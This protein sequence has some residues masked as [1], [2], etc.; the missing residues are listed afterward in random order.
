LRTGAPRFSA[1]LDEIQAPGPDKFE[2]RRLLNELPGH[3]KLIT[4][5]D[6]S[7]QIRSLGQF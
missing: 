3:V 2:L 1:T 7:R 4:Y 6:V 5:D